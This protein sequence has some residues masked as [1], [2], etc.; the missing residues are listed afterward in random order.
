MHPCAWKTSFFFC[1]CIC[2]MCVC[3]SRIYIVISSTFCL[4]IKFPVAMPMREQ[5]GHPPTMTYDLG[6][7]GLV[8]GGGA[9]EREGVRGKAHKLRMWRCEKYRL[10]KYSST[11]LNC[12]TVDFTWLKVLRHPR[13]IKCGVKRN[14][15]TK[16]G[17]LAAAKVQA[18]GL[19]QDL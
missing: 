12:M 7:S 8:R 5:S 9:E 11:V 2:S 16:E 4:V 14:G 6:L 3:I 10:S 17:Q 19:S 15:A 18:C 1:L 13:K